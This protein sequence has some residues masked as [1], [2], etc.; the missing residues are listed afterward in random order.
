MITLH[1]LPSGFGLPVSVSPYCAKVEVYC[2]LTGRPYDKTS[3]D[4]RKSPNRLVPY[5]KWPDGSVTAESD[6]IIARL[7]AQGDALDAGLSPE[8]K[9]RGDGAAMLA[10][11]VLY[12]ACLYARFADPAGWAHQKLLFKKMLPALLRPIVVPMIRK[13]QIKKCA[14]HGFASAASYAAGI[15]A[16]STLSN[17]IGDKP[18]LLGDEPR[19]ADCAVWANVMQTAYTLSPNPP[20][21]AVRNDPILMGYIQRMADRANLEM[22]PLK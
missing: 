21:D 15:E 2:R 6:A 19:I 18:F 13:S 5:V 3:G 20:R 22:P 8:D 16:A 1:E 11:T 9:V 7:E 17:E 10:Q 4:I 14:E 12:Y